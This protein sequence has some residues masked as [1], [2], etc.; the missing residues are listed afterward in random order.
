MA[1]GSISLFLLL[2][3]LLA[4]GSSSADAGCTRNSTLQHLTWRL[5][6]NYSKGVRP[7]R[8]WAQATTVYLD[9]FVHA[10][11]DV[12]WKDEFLTW[13]SSLH[14][15][16]REV[17]LLLSSIWSPDITINELV[18]VSKS[19]D[20]PYIYVNASGMVRN[21]KP[22]HVVSACQLEPYAFPFDTQTCSLTFSTILHTVEDV[23]LAAHAADNKQVFLADGEW[24]LL[25]V[26]TRYQV[27]STHS[28]RYAE[29]QFHIVIRRR[30][31]LYVVSLLIP[32][33]FLMAVDLGSFYLPPTCGTRI[34][35]KGSVLVGYTVFKVNMSAELPGTAFSTPLIGV[36]FTICMALLVLSLSLSILLV[37]SLHPGEVH[38]WQ[39]L[40]SHCYRGE[41]GLDGK[42]QG[43]NSQ[44]APACTEGA[45][46]PG[47][48]AVRGEEGPWEGMPTQKAA[49]EEI[50]AQLLLISSRLR[51]LHR[52]SRQEADW[53]RLSCKLDT[54]LFQVYAG[55][56]AVYAIT[57]SA[58]WA[59]WS[60]QQQEG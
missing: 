9:L 23:D 44:A 28:G 11:L 47:E 59:M 32:S 6:R 49:M 43:A 42:D 5:L 50:L 45:P 51:A 54:L 26:P 38:A 37:K 13:N 27:L 21:E 39:R 17:S 19:L 15:G 41:S 33:I 7:V 20:I 10:V 4:G 58:L 36:F 22:M 24:E 55:V 12:S 48:E 1:T 25:S 52:D 57:L 56:V 53:L 29:A 60:S 40:T 16:I 30:P 46:L 18:D 3:G 8:N 34:T 14:D 35:F 31:L 2:L